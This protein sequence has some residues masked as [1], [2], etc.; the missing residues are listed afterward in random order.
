MPYDCFISYNSIDIQHA[1]RLNAQLVAAGFNL[2]F[3]RLRLNPGCNWHEEIEE[4]CVNSRVVLPVLTPS[5]KQSEWTRF[6]TYGAE[7]VIPLIFEGAWPEVCTPPLEQYQAERF[8]VTQP[9]AAE[10]DRLFVALRRLLDRP[11]PQ[12]QDRLI[13]LQYRANDHFVGRDHDLTRIHEELHSNPRAVLSQGRVRAITAM[14]GVGKT[15]IARQYAEKFWKCYMQMFWVDARNGVDIEFAAIHDLLFPDRADIGMKPEDKAKRALHELCSP[16]ARL[17]VIDNAEDELSIADFIPA[18]GG[19]H[20]L[21][22]SRFFGWSESVTTL[23]LDLL[24]KP[25]AVEFLQLRTGCTASGSELE[26]CELL[27]DKL[28]CLPLALEQ[29]AVYIKK[30]RIGFAQYLHV[31]ETATGDLLAIRALGSTAYPDPVIKSL[32]P[33]VTRVG[34][35]ARAILRLASMVAVTPVSWHL[36]AARPDIVIDQARHLSVQSDVPAPA[37]AEFWILREIENLVDYSLVSFDGT[38]IRLHPLVTA[39]QL[40]TQSM[41]DRE[42]AWIAAAAL[43]T[44]NPPPVT[45][46]IDRREHWTAETEKRWNRL[47]PQVTRMLEIAE[48]IPADLPTPELALLAANAFASQNNYDRATSVCRALCDRLATIGQEPGPLLIEAKDC[49]SCLLK[50]SDR[51]SEAIGEFRALHAMIV[52]LAGEDDQYALWAQHNVACL[53]ELLGEEDEAESL[54]LD[55]LRR[56]RARLGE[57][58][59]DTTVSIHD[60]G[61]LM[62]NRNDRQA[63]AEVYLRMAVERWSNTLGSASPDTRAAISNLA[64]SVQRKGD[65]EEAAKIQRRLLDATRDVLSEDH[66][67]YFGVLHNLSLFEYNIGHLDE[68]CRLIRIVVD[69]YRRYLPPN[70]RDMLTAIQDLGTILGRLRQYSEAKHLLQEALAGYEKTQPLDSKYVVRTVRNMANLAY[71]S[72]EY[73][74]AEML[75][76]RLLAITERKSGTD[77]VE[78]ANGLVDL[79]NVYYRSHRFAD[80]EPAYK[81]ALDI[82]EKKL[83][84]GDPDVAVSLNNLATVY[85]SLGRYEEA[86]PL[87]RRALAIEERRFGADNPDVGRSLSNLASLMQASSQ[88]VEAT[89]AYERVLAINEMHFGHEHSETLSTI[90]ML[91]DLYDKIGQTEK[92]RE[93]RRR[94]LSLLS[95]NPD[96]K[97]LELRT[98]ALDAYLIGDFTLAKSLLVRVLDAGF[99]VPGTEC[100]LARVALMQGDAAACDL[101]SDKAWSHRAEAPPNIVPRIPWLQL[102]A[103][104][105]IDNAGTVPVFLGRLKTALSADG[106]IMQWSMDPVLEILRSKVSA[107]WHALLTSLVAALS[108]PGKV[109]DLDQFPEWREA[110]P[111]PL[112]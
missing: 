58:H 72:G 101:Y 23:Q 90:Q 95:G 18:T 71:V 82:R 55:V 59:Y 73:A 44:T 12:K 42:S 7:S 14:G 48:A 83:D 5:W 4:G 107:E 16:M 43:L 26:S 96:V 68:S 104:L 11:V 112:D 106:A 28:G 52:Q 81:R 54:M 47:V 41:G 29:A 111:L 63:E 46:K 98:A 22:T 9:D 56:R 50:Q 20:T 100:H 86:E 77:N 15:T 62:D 97:P 17:L 38:Y 33:S 76:S 94:R 110:E 2:W 92:G 39:I 79:G 69:G 84:E 53:L 78:Y 40:Q 70:H 75:F 108:Y 66:I 65:F 24:D 3:D 1:E 87:Y 103:A 105:L 35:A 88:Y 99:E 93:L 49:L 8:D 85:Q 31:Y 74:D 19:C 51:Y 57:E 60:V 61:W 27:A 36:F 64:R 67:D 30:M 13:R 21:I 10:W 45:W 80:A 34:P 109:A 102:V 37:N 6:E 89:A 25:A 32:Q 91:A